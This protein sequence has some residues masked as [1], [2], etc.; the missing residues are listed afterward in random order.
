M[1]AA[2]RTNLDEIQPEDAEQLNR[3]ID[4][5]NATLDFKKVLPKPLADAFQS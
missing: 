2:I 5:H 1:V 3:L 4:W